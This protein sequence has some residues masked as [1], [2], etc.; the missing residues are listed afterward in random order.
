MSKYVSFKLISAKD[1]R[2]Y[3]NGSVNIETIDDDE[4][5]FEYEQ[6]DGLFSNHIPTYWKTFGEDL[7]DD[8]NRFLESIDWD[9]FRQWLWDCQDDNDVFDFYG[10]ILIINDGVDKSTS[11]RVKQSTKIKLNSLGERGESYDD[12]IN[13]LIKRSGYL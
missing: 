8:F 7:T 1:E 2:I 3:L 13:K 4:A 9:M 5:E 12:I 10:H 11:L 6:N